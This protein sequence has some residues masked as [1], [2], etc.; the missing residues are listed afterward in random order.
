MVNTMLLYYVILCYTMLYYVILCYT[1]ILYY[2]DTYAIN[3]VLYYNIYIF[4][5][6]IYYNDTILQC[7]P[8]FFKNTV[9]FS[10]LSTM[11]HLLGSHG[12]SRHGSNA[13]PGLHGAPGSPGS[14]CFGRGKWW[15]TTRHCRFSE[16]LFRTNL[17]NHRILR[18]K[19]YVIVSDTLHLLADKW[20]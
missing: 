14:P 2:N 13:F 4:I 6:N 20:D 5:Y 12:S 10:K 11:D 15:S 8:M 17:W 7:I 19:I 1:T 9:S 16:F 3:L 18:N